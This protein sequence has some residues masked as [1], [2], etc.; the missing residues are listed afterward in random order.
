ML[1][2]EPVSLLLSTCSEEEGASSASLYTLLYTYI[3]CA[4]TKHSHPALDHKDGGV[5]A[6]GR[7]K[8]K[9]V[10]WPPTRGPQEMPFKN[11]HRRRRGLT[12]KTKGILS[13]SNTWTRPSMHARSHTHSTTYACIHTQSST[14]RQKASNHFFPLSTTNSFMDVD[15]K[16]TGT[17]LHQEQ[18]SLANRPHWT[19]GGVWVGV[20]QAVSPNKWLLFSPPDGLEVHF[21]RQTICESQ[22]RTQNWCSNAFS[23]LSKLSTCVCQTRLSDIWG[24]NTPWKVANSSSFSVDPRWTIG[25]TP[26]RR[27]S[28]AFWYGSSST[29]L[30]KRFFFFCSYQH[31]RITDVTGRLWSPTHCKSN[32]NL[33]SSLGSRGGPKC[34]GCDFRHIQANSQ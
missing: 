12:P 13:L 8:K 1:E 28:V 6:Q 10:S 4:E 19:G 3:F 18:A 27:I 31:L 7:K 32:T 29:N 9:V 30:S 11:L 24:V 26:N 2:K 15:T 22:G 25:V 20:G 34:R 33:E 5:G 14:T 17:W 16:T 21:R 23:W